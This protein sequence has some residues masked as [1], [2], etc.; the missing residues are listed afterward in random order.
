MLRARWTRSVA[1]SRTGSPRASSGG[2]RTAIRAKNCSVVI[3][4][5]RADASPG[6]HWELLGDAGADRIPPSS[7]DAATRAG[8]SSTNARVWVTL[9]VGKEQIVLALVPRAAMFRWNSLASGSDS[10]L[11]ERHP[12]R[13]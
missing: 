3:M 13:P 7:D 5:E 10:A 1:P 4:G 9:F 6:D 2:A 11:L 8:Q 12:D